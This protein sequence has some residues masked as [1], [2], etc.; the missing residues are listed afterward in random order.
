LSVAT[1]NKVLGGGWFSQSARPVS[2]PSSGLVEISS[3]GFSQ[4]IAK[5]KLSGEMTFHTES[6]LWDY[7][8]L[9]TGAGKGLIHYLVLNK[10][11]NFSDLPNITQ[12]RNSGEMDRIH[13]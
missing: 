13:F 3:L 12:Y 10:L 5:N 9:A 6:D 1:G 11:T 4:G 8:I 2:F 7:T